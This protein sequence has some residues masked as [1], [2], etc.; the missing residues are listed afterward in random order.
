MAQTVAVLFSVSISVSAPVS[1]SVSVS[2]TA[3]A[4]TTATTGLH[5]ARDQVAVKRLEA[6]EQIR[7]LGISVEP[8][9]LREALGDER[10][11]QWAVAVQRS[12]ATSA[13]GLRGKLEGHL[14]AGGDLRMQAVGCLG[15][16]LGERGLQLERAHDWLTSPPASGLLPVQC[17][18]RAPEPQDVA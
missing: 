17:A 9:Q 15:D 14:P 6:V 10:V 12:R 3:T 5:T 8:A 4:A 11:G 16:E 7:G 2:A 18:L 1:I 13:T